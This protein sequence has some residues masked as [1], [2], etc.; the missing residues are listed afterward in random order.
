MFWLCQGSEYAWSSY[1]F[2]RLLKIPQVLNVPGFLV[3]HR[4]ICKVYTELNIVVYYFL[5]FHWCPFCPVL[6]EP[7]LYLWW[8]LLSRVL[9]EP[10]M[11]H[12]LEP[13]LV[14]YQEFSLTWWCLLFWKTRVFIKDLFLTL[15]FDSLSQLLSCSAY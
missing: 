9:L 8:S 7:F 5:I 15:L 10:L 1:M 2:Y 12:L 3:W 13:F 11:S 14:S 6:G 4:C